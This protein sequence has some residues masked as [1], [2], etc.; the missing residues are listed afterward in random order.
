MLSEKT[1]MPR[2]SLRATR[3]SSFGTTAT[4]YSLLVAAAHGEG[5]VVAPQEDVADLSWSAWSSRGWCAQRLA[6]TALESTVRVSRR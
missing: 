5:P 6:S 4:S 3:V 2:R 1:R